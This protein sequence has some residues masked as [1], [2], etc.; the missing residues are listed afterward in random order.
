MIRPVDGKK[1]DI[2]LKKEDTIKELT[3]KQKQKLLS[4][5]IKKA[6]DEKMKTQ[7]DQGYMKSKESLKFLDVKRNQICYVKEAIKQN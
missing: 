5:E 1:L 6:A 4:E 3:Y 2:S 7:Y